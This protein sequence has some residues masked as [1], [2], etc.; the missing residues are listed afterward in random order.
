M[1]KIRECVH[2]EMEFDTRSTAKRRAGGK[3]NECP[4]CVEEYGTETTVK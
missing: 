2:C 1:P 4:D 3:I